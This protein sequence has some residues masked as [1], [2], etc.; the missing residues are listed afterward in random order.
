MTASHTSS[1]ARVPEIAASPPGTYFRASLSLG[2]K[3]ALV[4]WPG[5]TSLVILL[6][7]YGGRRSDEYSRHPDEVYSP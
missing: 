6:A 4:F 2:A 1:I 5:F 7:E 3:S